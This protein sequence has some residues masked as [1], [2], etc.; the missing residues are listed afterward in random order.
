MGLTRSQVVEGALVLLHPGNESVAIPL[1]TGDRKDSGLRGIDSGR[2][3]HAIEDEG[4]LHRG[5]AD[6]L[7]PVRE[8]MVLDQGKPPAPPP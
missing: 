2:E 6:A 4:G 5:I 8:G 1:T 7:V 3:L